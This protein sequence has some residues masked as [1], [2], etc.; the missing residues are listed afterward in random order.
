[1]ALLYSR[2]VLWMLLVRGRVGTVTVA[3]VV[4]AAVWW[5]LILGTVVLMVPTHGRAAVTSVV[6]SPAGRLAYIYVPPGAASPIPADWVIFDAYYQALGD[7]DEDAIIRI[8]SRPGWI[9]VVDHQA[10]RVVGIYG[11][12]IQV[13]VL[14]GQSAG[15]RAWLKVYQLSP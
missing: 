5:L 7:V 9:P 6:V 1:M 2:T 8:L 15:V 3:L 4:G 11:D 12:A 10:M 13:E 14:D